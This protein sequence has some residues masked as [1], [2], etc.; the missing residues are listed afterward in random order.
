MSGPVVVQGWHSR[1]EAYQAV[2][3]EGAGAIFP[4]V[5][6]LAVHHF[7]VWKL[8][9]CLKTL[10]QAPA[11]PYKVLPGDCVQVT[12]PASIVFN[13]EHLLA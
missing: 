13:T 4:K 2:L 1:V 11:V 7:V 6:R 10:R 8:R 5:H 9:L 12:C 3:P